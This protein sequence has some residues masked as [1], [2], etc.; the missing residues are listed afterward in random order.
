M[1]QSPAQ[2]SRTDRSIS[3]IRNR[4]FK[5]TRIELEWSQRIARNLDA[6]LPRSN[7]RQFWSTAPASSLAEVNGRFLGKIFELHDFRFFSKNMFSK[8]FS[9]KDSQVYTILLVSLPSS[10]LLAGSYVLNLDSNLFREPQVRTVFY[11]V[12]SLLLTVGGSI[13]GE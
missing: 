4:F 11:G 7:P 10:A 1:S 12:V 9:Y 6:Y 8:Y 5:T 13:S 3:E 2:C